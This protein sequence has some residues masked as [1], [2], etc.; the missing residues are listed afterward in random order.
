MNYFFKI[1]ILLILSQTFVSCSSNKEKKDNS[2]LYAKSQQ[3]DAIIERSGTTFRAGS[4][5]G[6]KREQMQ[7]AQNRLRTGGGLFGKKGGLNLLDLGGSSG[8]VASIGMPINPF[9]WKG[10]LETVEFMPLLSAD[11]FAGIIIT[12]WYSGNQDITERCKVNIFI[13]GLELNSQNLKVNTFCQQLNTN[14]IWIDKTLKE[15]NNIKLENAIFN[16]AK[17][18]RLAS[19]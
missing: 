10:S 7:D 1:A 2:D 6:D 5:K 11:P 17:K 8:Q 19:N 18:L 13:K 16:K 15:E 14:N 9:L 4:N 3:V 12:D